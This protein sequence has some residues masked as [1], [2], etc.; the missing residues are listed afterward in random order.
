MGTILLALSEHLRLP[1]D[2][3]LLFEDWP[4]DNAVRDFI[5]SAAGAPVKLID[6]ELV[7]KP[8][9]P[10][11]EPKS[12]FARRIAGLEP[13]PPTQNGEFLS[14]DETQ[15][16]LCGLEESFRKALHNGLSAS[17]SEAVLATYKSRGLIT[18][19]GQ[20]T[21]NGSNGK[22]VSSFDREAG[23]LELGAQV[24]GYNSDLQRL[25]KIGCGRRYMEGELKEKRP[26]LQIWDAI[27]RSESLS[28]RHR[29]E[30]FETALSAYHVEDR[31]KFIGR[32]VGK[33]SAALYDLYK[34]YRDSS[35]QK[36]NRRKTHNNTK[37]R[38]IHTLVSE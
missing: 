3:T 31:F 26:E 34:A 25:A 5:L 2:G 32:I 22:R 21:N 14:V 37:P 6:G 33:S 24:S 7:T 27:E 8:T 36:Q 20:P 38:K 30:F 1:T 15:K 35:G 9:L 16:V 10:R 12:K 18:L 11:C 29:R 17:F 4:A 19:A 13:D 23:K 28:P